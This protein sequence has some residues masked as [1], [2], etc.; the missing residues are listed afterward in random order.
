MMKEIAVADAYGAGFEFRDDKE[1]LEKNDLSGY[2]DHK[3]YG[4]SAKY[5]DDTQMS[6]AIAEF[7]L[8]GLPWSADAVLSK[9]FDCFKRDPRRGYASGFYE[10]LQKSETAKY[11][12]KNI[13]RNSDR[14]GAAVRA[15][16]IGFI[17]DQKDVLDLAKI[18]AVATHNSESGI[19]SSC[20]VALAVHFGARVNGSVEDLESFLKSSRFGN[21]RFDWRERVS[22][23]ATDTISAALSCIIRSKKLSCL[24]HECVN[25]GS[26]TDSVAAIAV[27]IASSF[28]EYEKDI[29]RHLFDRLEEPIYGLS[30][31]D[32]LDE[33][34]AKI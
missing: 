20:A 1:I 19:A 33:K 3:L 8:E 30:Y 14:N 25:L 16:P 2:F 11:L 12:I 9:I 15:M 5:T 17:P 23:K 34:L 4:F 21:W 31:L 32:Q 7:M 18:Q 10:L 28:P 29:P 13:S 26:D 22:V 6:I 24:L 27:G